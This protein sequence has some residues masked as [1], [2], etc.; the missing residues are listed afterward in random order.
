LPACGGGVSA[1]SA[2]LAVHVLPSGGGTVTAA[3]GAPTHPTGTTPSG[4]RHT[5]GDLLDL[6]RWYLTLPIANLSGR[7]DSGPWDVYQAEL[8]T[9]NHP[10]YLRLVGDTV[11]YAAPVRGISTSSASGATRCELR[12]MDCPGRQNKADWG[13][14]DGKDHS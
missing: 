8:R 12:E 1:L 13:F 5:P 10:K 14:D 6:S 3:T 7:D 11:E 4:D 9:F 2:L